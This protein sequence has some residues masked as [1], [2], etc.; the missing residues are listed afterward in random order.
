[1]GLRLNR[2]L[3]TAKDL[4]CRRTPR[5]PK[6]VHALPVDRDLHSSNQ[7]PHVDLHIACIKRAQLSPVSRND[8][9]GKAGL[10][11]LQLRAE[12]LLINLNKAG[13]SWALLQRF[14]RVLVS[15]RL[16]IAGDHFGSEFFVGDCKSRVSGQKILRFVKARASVWKNF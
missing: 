12:S 7:L 16:S 15:E 10:K 14:A 6:A 13:W 3:R 4:N 9:T 2:G 8:I 11:G 5:R 1:L